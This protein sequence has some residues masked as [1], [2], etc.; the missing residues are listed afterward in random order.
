MPKEEEEKIPNSSKA[1][2]SAVREGRRLKKDMFLATC[3]SERNG[4]HPPQS[5]VL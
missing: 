1:T 2:V 3:E 4:K 5:E